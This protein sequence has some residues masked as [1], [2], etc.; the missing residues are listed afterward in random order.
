MLNFLN[1]LPMLVTPEPINSSKFEYI[2]FKLIQLTMNDITT[3][4]LQYLILFSYLLNCST[5]HL[6]NIVEQL[7]ERCDFD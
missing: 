5:I 7:K 3:L 4:F 6:L 2:L 1:L